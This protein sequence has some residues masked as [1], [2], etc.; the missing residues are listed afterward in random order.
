[1]SSKNGPKGVPLVINNFDLEDSSEDMDFSNVGPLVG[2]LKKSSVKNS[3][4]SAKKS[5]SRREDQKKACKFE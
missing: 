2:S 4:S 3:S 5:R 1:M